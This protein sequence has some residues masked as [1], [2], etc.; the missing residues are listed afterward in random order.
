MFFVAVV[1]VAVV[2]W[3]EERPFKGRVKGDK[4]W[5]LAP[6]QR[7]PAVYTKCKT[8]LKLPSG[9]LILEARSI[10]GGRIG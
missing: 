1:R 6:A 4:L 8:A 9:P 5:A 10:S 7:T 3:V 2:R